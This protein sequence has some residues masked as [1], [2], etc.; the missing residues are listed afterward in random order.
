MHELHQT[1]F[2]AA[3]QLP[4]PV[5]YGGLRLDLGFRLDILVEGCVV[6]EIKAVDAISPVHQAQLLTYLKLSH[7]HVGLLIN[8]NVVHCETAYAGW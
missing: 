4:L 2:R 3:V 5:I 8:F 7:N 1:G 6:V